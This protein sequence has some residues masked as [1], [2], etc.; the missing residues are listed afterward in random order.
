MRQPLL[1]DHCTIRVILV[2]HLSCCLKKTCS[3][4][5]CFAPSVVRRV[6][7]TKAYMKPTCDFAWRLIVYRIVMSTALLLVGT[8]DRLTLNPVSDSNFVAQG[9]DSSRFTSLS[10]KTA[11]QG[12]VREDECKENTV[13]LFKSGNLELQVIL[14]CCCEKAQHQPHPL[15]VLQPKLRCFS[16]LSIIGSFNELVVVMHKFL[17]ASI[18]QNI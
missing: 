14:F 7:S 11:I 18:R 3:G 16:L 12:V 2:H 5:P 4:V 17:T 13:H 10:K 1:L 8:S 6:V 9:C 15:C